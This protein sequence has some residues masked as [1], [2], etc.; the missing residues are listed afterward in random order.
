MALQG[1]FILRPANLFCG[2]QIFLLIYYQKSWYSSLEAWLTADWLLWIV[3]DTEIQ[4]WKFNQLQIT[5]SHLNTA[6]TGELTFNKK[7]NSGNDYN[8]R[9]CDNQNISDHTKKCKHQEVK[10]SQPDSKPTQAVGTDW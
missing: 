6:W 4:R 9:A 8:D 10:E 3:L 2:W 1:C 5:I 7:E